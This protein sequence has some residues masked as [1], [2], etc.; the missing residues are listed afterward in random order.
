VDRVDL[1]RLL[2]ELAARGVA[3]LMVEG[4]ART[5]WE[6]FGAG[7]VDAVAVFVA[8]RVLGGEA[9]IGAVGGEGFRLARAADVSAVRVERIGDDLLVTGRVEARGQGG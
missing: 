4:G 6:F 3:S 1:A 2:R 5:L 7:L 8:P 9:A